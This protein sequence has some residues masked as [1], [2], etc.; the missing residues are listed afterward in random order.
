MRAV[1]QGMVSLRGGER[2]PAGRRDVRGTGTGREG[3]PTV[4]AN[5]RRPQ[6]AV[7]H[8]W[9]G[10]PS[11]RVRA[12]R[13]GPAEPNPCTGRHS[14]RAPS[15]RPPGGLG[16]RNS[17]W[18]SPACPCS[19]TCRH[20]GIL[21]TGSDGPASGPNPGSPT[22]DSTLRK[23]PY[24]KRPTARPAPPVRAGRGSAESGDLG[25]GATREGVQPGCRFAVGCSLEGSTI[26][27]AHTS[28]TRQRVYTHTSL[29][30][31]R[32]H[33]CG[34]SPALAGASGL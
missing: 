20:R 33:S 10:W 16:R 30:R 14:G 26:T 21:C 11:S 24:R 12:A 18:P 22:R 8:G 31:E 32:V 9:P 29:K 34:A 15:P 28:T 27:S 3:S 1:G 17:A 2:L 23:R 5:D 7:R 19:S 6:K 25:P 4:R 13:P